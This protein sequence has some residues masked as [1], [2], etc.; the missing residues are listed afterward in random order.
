VSGGAVS[1]GAVSGASWVVGWFCSSSIS[2]ESLNPE[3]GARL[4]ALDSPMHSCADSIR[5]GRSSPDENDSE[6]EARSF[7]LS[8][9][10]SLDLPGS[11]DTLILS[12]G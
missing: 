9:A 11:M 8:R 7:S 1:G 10:F 6:V 4:S 2:A 5:A 12:E 3:L